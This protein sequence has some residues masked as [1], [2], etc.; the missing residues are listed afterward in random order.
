[1]GLI[2]RFVIASSVDFWKL[3]VLMLRVFIGTFE[4]HCEFIGGVANAEFVLA[5]EVP[6]LIFV[7]RSLVIIESTRGLG[8]LENEEIAQKS[9]NIAEI[10]SILHRLSNC[11]W[12]SVRICVKKRSSYKAYTKAKAGFVKFVDLANVSLKT[13]IYDPRYQKYEIADQYGA[14]IKVRWEDFRKLAN[15]SEDFVD[16]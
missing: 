6:S 9:Y 15:V 16:R 10:R 14:D 1:M 2:R 11:R 13:K 3:N 7:V 8:Y 5:V 12:T 4:T